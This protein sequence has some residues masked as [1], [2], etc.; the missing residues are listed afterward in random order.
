VAITEC[1]WQ[2]G[3]ESEISGSVPI[4]NVFDGQT[5]VLAD[6]SLKPVPRGVE[7]ELV[8][9]GSQ[10]T[11]GYLNNP[12]ATQ[13][14]FVTLPGADGLWYRTGD[15]VESDPRYGLRYRGRADQQ[16]KVRGFRV[17]G[18]EVESHVRAT[19][20]SDLV[21]VIGWP[22]NEEG[23]VMGLVAF[24]V[25]PKFSEAT[26]IESCRKRMPDYMVPARVVTVAE[27]PLGANGKVDYR[28]LSESEALS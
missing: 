2:D 17:E 27:L 24:V 25:S 11:R 28:A 15:L 14:K 19:S 1:V 16:L 10:V 20:G 7:G 21:A 3:W 9:S 8:V 12:E 22:K 26:I 13:E 18:Q 5:V 4:G 23:L 6:E